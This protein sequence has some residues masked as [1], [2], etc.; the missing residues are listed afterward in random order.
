[1]VYEGALVDAAVTTFAGACFVYVA[2][3][4]YRRNVARDAFALGLVLFYF[5]V[6]VS[7]LLAGLRQ[8]AFF[9]SGA[10]PPAAAADR[11]LFGMLILPGAF[12]I[13]PLVHL[14]AYVRTGRA[15]VA[16]VFA[17]AFALLA[18]VGAGSVFADGIV[19]PVLGFWG[20]EWTIASPLARDLLLVGVAAAFVSGAILVHAGHGEG[21]RRVRLVGW[22]C[23][24]VYAALA[25][26]NLSVGH[27][28]VLT[29]R[30]LAA[31]AALLAYRAYFP[32]AR[33][34]VALDVAA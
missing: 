22:S 12:S 2:S 31:T 19:G 29:F 32:S 9:V 7:F 5:G 4:V 15:Q 17:A 28:P 26:D 13:V 21:G 23:I 14:A 16:A 11:A 27:G 30:L 6:G 25:L 18:L 8:G 3:E 24:I 10:F 34:Q 33:S 1:M 20:S